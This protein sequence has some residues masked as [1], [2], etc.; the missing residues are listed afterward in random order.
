MYLKKITNYLKYFPDLAKESR[1]K[2]I[3]TPK[4]T[5]KTNSSII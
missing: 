1:T 5:Y 3:K 4:N 2:I